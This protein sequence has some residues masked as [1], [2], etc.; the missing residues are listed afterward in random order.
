[1]STAKLAFRNFKSSLR[2]YLILILSLAF[3]VMIL[4]HFQTLLY[5]SGFDVLGTRNKEYI[6]LLIQM[7]SFVLGCFMFF[8]IWY[9]TNVFLTR[10]KREI[11]I[12]VFMGLSNEQIG[13]MYL[14]EAILIGAA[15][16]ALGL[17]F[18]TLGTGLFQMIL[19]KL[20]DLAVE[21]QFTPGLRPVL[22]TTLVYGMIYLVFMAKGYIDIVR[23]SVL[24][25]ISAAKQNEYV[26][27]KQGWLA[28][29]AVLGTALLVTGYYL[30]C[31]EG[32]DSVMGNALLAVILVT[33]GVYLLFG[34]MIPAGFQALAGNKRFLYRGQRILWVNSF[35]F[36][37][38][39]NY[40]TYAIVCIL[41]LC[42]VTALATG[43][44]LKGRYET[45][46]QFENT[47]TFQ[48]LSSRDDLEGPARE[49][50]EEHSEILFDA[51]LSLLYLDQSVVEADAY[52]SRFGILAY[53]QVKQLAQRTGLEFPFQELAEDEVI[54]A[55][56]QYL[57]SMITAREDVDIRIHGTTYHQIQDTSIPYLGYLQES[58]GYYIVND[59]AYE[60]LR[61]LGEEVYVYNYRIQDTENF[62]KI[63][64]RLDQLVENTP[65]NK[66]ARIA[67]DPN[68]NE[69]DW[70]K[71]LYTICIF[72]FQVFV[73]AGG[74]IM[75]MKLSHDTWEERERSQVILKLGFDPGLLKRAAAAEL[76]TAYGLTFLVMAISS[77]FSVR[78][79][80]NMMFTDLTAVNLVSAG[81]VFGILLIWYLLSVQAYGQGYRKNEK[82]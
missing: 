4:F 33:G 53:S 60:R 40:R 45:I 15:A 68:S 6:E 22:T 19:R 5:S 42:S 56:H 73:L 11:G 46:V 12:Y 75:F 44:A 48:L 38:R 54:K 36:R 76:G 65:E 61:S 27:Q 17:G 66:T 64:D 49:L 32:R 29:K 81:V 25:M 59:Q 28:T 16:W 69:L 20:S 74:S 77:V 3:S 30:A 39:R 21:I 14:I 2:H 51:R 70:V 82:R 57:L 31:K 72:L 50:I 24:S 63:R 9:S 1:M 67:M 78:A 55:S 34:G 13:Q 7:T 23:S 35:I 71:M 43:F 37:L 18:G 10:R 8:F 52:Y 62:A 79:L 58:S 26:Q 47:Y 41:M 80:G